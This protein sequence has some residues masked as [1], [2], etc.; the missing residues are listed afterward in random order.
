MSDKSCKQGIEQVQER[1]ILQSAKVEEMTDMKSPFNIKCGDAIFGVWLVGF[2]SSF[3]PVFLVQYFLIM[4]PLL[5]FEIVMCILCC[6]M[7]EICNLV[8]VLNFTR[9]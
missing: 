3:D 4:P 7:L 1:R 2:W 5:H 9:G 8:L 6:C